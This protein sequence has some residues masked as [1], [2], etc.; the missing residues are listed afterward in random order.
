MSS[1]ILFTDENQVFSAT[2]TLATSAVDYGVPKIFTSKALIVPHLQFIMCGI[3]FQGFLGRWFIEVNDKMVVNGIDNLDYHTPKALSNLWDKF[4]IE[5]SLPNEFITSVYHSGFSETDNHIHNYLYQSVY[6]FKSQQITY[7]TLVKPETH[8]PSQYNFPEDVRKI[9]D[10]QRAIQQI[11][12]INQR[13]FIG[14]EF[15]HFISQG[16][17]VKFIR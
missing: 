11:K 13:I 8:L 14:G 10:R 7:G 16:Q 15:K 5:N 17:S 12:P 4:R 9:M 3:G 1:L 2:D 6:G